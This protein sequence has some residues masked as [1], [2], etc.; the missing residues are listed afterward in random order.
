M[1]ICN[2]DQPGAPFP[3]SVDAPSALNQ[4][5]NNLTLTVMSS[6]APV[7]AAV[8]TVT[9][10]IGNHPLHSETFYAQ[11][12]TD[13]EGQVTLG[14][15]AQE[16]SQLYYGARLHNYASLTGTMEVNSQGI[17]GGEPE[18]LRLLPVTPSPA[19]VS[20]AVSFQAPAGV[21]VTV[22]IVDLAGRTA[23]VLHD[24]PAP[25]GLFTMELNTSS[26]SP[27]IYFAVLQAEGFTATEKIAVVR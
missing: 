9:D 26:M 23:A 19:S 17:H 5:E 7:Q 10:G 27:G 15:N 22:R 25:G 6:G 16:G 2:S 21:R 11:G 3:M 4:G 20:A 13:A 18:S 12:I 1:D 8:V 14:F 24:M